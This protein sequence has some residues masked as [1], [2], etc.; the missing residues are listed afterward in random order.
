MPQTLLPFQNRTYPLFYRDRIETHTIYSDKIYVIGF[1]NL[2]IFS[3]VV[4]TELATEGADTMNIGSLL[5]AARSDTRR[6]HANNIKKA[7]GDWHSFS[8]GPSKQATSPW[9]W[10]H[11]ECARLLCPPT[12]EWNET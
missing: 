4:K 11:A 6:S 3:S 8:P 2:L 5:D 1:R 9:G 7:I 10:D 12:I